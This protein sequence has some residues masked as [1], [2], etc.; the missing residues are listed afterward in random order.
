MNYRGLWLSRWYY[1]ESRYKTIEYLD[2]D[3]TIFMEFLDKLL[4]FFSVDPFCIYASLAKNTREFVNE[5]LPGLYSL[6]KTYPLCT[7]MVAKV[8]SIIMTLL[9]FKERVEDIL[10]EKKK[11]QRCAYT[12]FKSK[13]I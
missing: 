6:K 2:K 4:K 1:G 11:I 7:E 8:D 10:Q 3:F 9:D 13:E 5:I 12:K